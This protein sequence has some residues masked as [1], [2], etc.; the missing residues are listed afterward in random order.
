MRRKV[1]VVLIVTTLCVATVLFVDT[2]LKNAQCH[3][4]QGITKLWYTLQNDCIPYYFKNEKSGGTDSEKAGK[5]FL[6]LLQKESCLPNHLR[7]AE[8]IGKSRYCHCNVLVL[9]YKK[10]CKETTPS[11]AHVEYLYAPSSTWNT[12][13]NLLFTTAMNR[14]E[15]YLYYIFMDDDIILKTVTLCK[16]PWREFENFLAE[17]EPAVGVVDINDRKKLHFVYEGRKQQGCGSR[18]S[19]DY[20]PIAHF[21]S[22]FNAFHYKAVQHILPY[23]TRFDNISWWYSGWYVSIKNEALFAGQS[24][25]YTKL[26]A[27]NYK[28]RPY[29]RSGFKFNMS[30]YWP[31][32]MKEVISDIPEEYRN[33]ALILEWTKDGPNHNQRSSALCSSKIVPHMPIKPFAYLEEIV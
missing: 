32:I 9:S 26:T 1:V 4:T 20:L 30:Y 12:G 24:L 5:T 18:E 25:V 31:K 14:S 19:P 28:H 29:P 7:S 16:N 3:V 27:L 21:D 10:A 2:C 11:L 17:I 15:K 23:T 22:A 33:V 13:R 8:A 6:Y